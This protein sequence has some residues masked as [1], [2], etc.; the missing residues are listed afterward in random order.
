[1]PH[2]RAF[3]DMDLPACLCAHAVL[4]RLRGDGFAGMALRE[5][6]LPACRTTCLAG[7]GVSARQKENVVPSDRLTVLGV[8][9]WHARGP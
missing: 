4:A 5:M 8:R 3:A 2:R 1:M 6:P 9:R 7:K